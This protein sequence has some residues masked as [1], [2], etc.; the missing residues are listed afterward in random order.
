MGNVDGTTLTEIIRSATH[1]W[2]L[3]LTDQEQA[4]PWVTLHRRPTEPMT[5]YNTWFLD[6]HNQT[7]RRLAPEA[8]RITAD[9][10]TREQ[11]G[12]KRRHAHRTT[13]WQS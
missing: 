5:L 2:P 4:S 6:F 10:R 11:H 1:P 3:Q 9:T 7:P 8:T 13:W 12:T